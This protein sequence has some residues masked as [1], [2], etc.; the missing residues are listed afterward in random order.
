[1]DTL[2]TLNLISNEKRYE[3]EGIKKRSN[4]RE[5]DIIMYANQFKL[6]FNG[7]SINYTS[8][9]YCLCD[10]VEALKAQR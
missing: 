4:L 9:F 5:N 10:K 3:L 6:K 1:M 2:L 7:R 8:Y